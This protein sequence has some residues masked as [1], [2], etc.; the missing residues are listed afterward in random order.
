MV[1]RYTSEQLRNVALVGASAGKTTLADLMLFKAGA[2]AR[3]GR[4]A[5]GTSALDFLPE[6]KAAHHTHATKL[7][8]FAWGGAHVNLLDTPGYPDF[9]GEAMAALAAVDAVLVVVDANGALPFHA[10]RL[11]ATAREL[12]LA[13]FLVFDRMDGEHADFAVACD[14]ARERL[15]KDCLPALLPDASGA[16]F[17]KLSWVLAPGG[18]GAARK[19]LLEAL[20]ES[21]DAALAT[22]LEKGDLPAEQLDALYD[23]A[24]RAGKLV[25]IL[26]CSGERDLGVS[27]LLDHVV[28]HAPSPRQAAGRPV[29]AAEGAAKDAVPARTRCDEPLTA[30]VWKTLSDPHAGKQSWLRVWSGTLRHE[31]PLLLARTGKPERLAHLFKPQGKALEP[32]EEAVAGDLV[33]VPKAEHL[34]TGDTV[35]DPAHPRALAPLAMPAGMVSLAVDAENKNDEPKMVEA[36]RRLAAEDLTFTEHRDP[37]THDLVVT[38]VSNL[39][40]ETL[41]KRVQERFHVG[42]KT[43][44]PRVALKETVRGQSEGHYRH[45]K[46]TG[47]S[48]QFAEVHL[49]VEPRERGAGFEFVDEVTQGK[50]PRQFIPAIEKGIV[51]GLPGGAFAGHPIVDVCVRVRDGKYHDVDSNE[52][53]FR[54]AGWRA[55]KDAFAKAHPVLL[56]PIVDLSVE[57]PAAAIGDVTGDLHSRRGRIVGVDVHGRL[58]VVRAQVPLREILDYSTRLRSMTAGEGSFTYAPSHDD[59]VPPQLATA[60]AAAYRPRDEE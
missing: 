20:A 13:T 30:Q 5:D 55:F 39:H 43:R 35:C 15:G 34:V 51:A 32:L 44:P 31:S 2:A 24:V 45:K 29:A 21:D 23:A 56:E 10:R 60:L 48:G 18:D 41:L 19:A 27:E 8:H 58:E 7:V 52:T 1:A 3:R 12:G 59:L 47:G 22:Y 49:V 17:S 14:H 42:I 4:T 53:A 36:L 50:I 46:Q 25:P 6:E 40:L 9:V 57:V 33:T 11:F 26:C 54:I 37:A 16:K 28:K 38:G